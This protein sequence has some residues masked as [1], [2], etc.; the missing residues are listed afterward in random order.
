M[1]TT[2]RKWFLPLAAA[3]LVMVG[4]SVQEAALIPVAIIRGRISNS[5]GARN[6]QVRVNRVGTTSKRLPVS[7]ETAFTDV[8]GDFILKTNHLDGGFVVARGLEF[9]FAY[10]PVFIEH[11]GDTISVDRW[12]TSTDGE[13]ISTDGVLV[14]KTPGESLFVVFE[15]D[16]EPDFGPVVRIDLV[17]PG[18]FDLDA[19]AIPLH[20]DGSAVDL[21]PVTPGK[22]ASGDLAAGDR[23]WTVRVGADRFPAGEQ[24][25]GY[26]INENVELGIQRDPYEEKNDDDHSVILVK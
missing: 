18:K 15:E 26:F 1:M 3:S 7:A 16:F 20:D 5:C 6:V 13:T 8:E 25:Y 19:T 4:C 14:C 12:L 2:R 21:D 23:V 17:G 11:F 22:Q 9:D 10:V 24:A